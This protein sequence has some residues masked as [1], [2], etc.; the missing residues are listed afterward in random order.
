MSPCRRGRRSCADRR[1]ARWVRIDLDARPRDRARRDRRSARPGRHYLE[2]APE[3]V[4]DYL[5][6]LDAINFGSGW[7]PTL[8]K[9]SEGRRLVGGYFT[10]AWALA[11][12]VRA[13]GP[14][15]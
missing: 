4:A 5:L 6:A 12:H 13:H 10:V 14:P 1:Q 11:E 15:R 7:F 8:H 3:D 2:G 9:R